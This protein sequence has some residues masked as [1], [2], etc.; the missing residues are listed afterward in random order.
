MAVL[1][2][3]RSKTAFRLFHP[4]NRDYCVTLR[5]L[6]NFKAIIL[7]IDLV[8]PTINWSLLVHYLANR[9]QH[10]GLGV[11]IHCSCYS[12]K[13][14]LFG[15]HCPILVLN[16]DSDPIHFLTNRHIR[17]DQSAILVNGTVIGGLQSPPSGWYEAIIQGAIYLAAVKTDRESLAVQQLAVSHAAH[18]ALLWIFHGTRLYATVN[19]K[20]RAILPEIGVDATSAAGINA[21]EVGRKAAK[22]VVIARTD[23]GINDFVDYIPILAAPGVYQQ[24]PGGQ[25]IPDTPQA[26]FIRLFGGLGDVTRFRAPPPPKPDSAEFETALYFVKAQGSRNST[27][28]KSYDTQTAY[29]WR[30]SSPMYVAVDIT[31]SI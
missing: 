11:D 14:C 4:A 13:C 2:C 12:S 29:F 27:V 26:E 1:G 20:L 23:D 15:G 18:D 30:E 31:Y 16:T 3:F 17:V 5:Q 6:S 10:E 7:D 9:R 25:L 19:A 24:T 21:I 28:R 22:K 8:D